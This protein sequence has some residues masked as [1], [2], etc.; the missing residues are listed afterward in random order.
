MSSKSGEIV[1]FVS[2]GI[3]GAC[4]IAVSQPL[5]YVKVI[6]ATQRSQAYRQAITN[7]NRISI[8]HLLFTTVQ[9]FG[10]RKL[11]RGM[12]LPIMAQIC[13]GSLG[14]LAFGSVNRWLTKEDQ[15]NRAIHD[16]KYL[17][18]TSLLSGVVAGILT[19]VTIHPSERI[20]V[21]MQVSYLQ[22]IMDLAD[23]K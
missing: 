7:G 20:K 1:D 16:T 9:Q 6:L 12:G 23:V 17:F 5:D 18:K 15:S 4:A 8:R 21:L 13:R 3:A 10:I 2:G 14:F 19:S 22:L 11:Y